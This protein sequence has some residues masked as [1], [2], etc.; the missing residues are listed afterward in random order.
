MKMASQSRGGGL[1]GFTGFD[2]GAIDF[3]LKVEEV[4]ET[5]W[6][7]VAEKLELLGEI[8]KKYWNKKE[9]E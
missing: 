1:G 3:V 7:Y 2:Y 4:P 8:A 9:E 5:L 6:P